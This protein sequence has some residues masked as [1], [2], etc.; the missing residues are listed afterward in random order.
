MLRDAAGCCR[1][2]LRTALREFDVN[3]RRGATIS[4]A[5]RIIAAA[6]IIVTRQY[7]RCWRTCPR[8]TRE[9]HTCAV[10]A[11]HINVVLRLRAGR[12]ATTFQGHELWETFAR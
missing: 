8:R 6:A 12:C 5:C 7:K 4:R 2:N 10:T 9:M 11:E 1:E 3:N